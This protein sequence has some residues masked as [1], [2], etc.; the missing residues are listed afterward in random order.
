METT[1]DGLLNQR[2]K[3]EQPAQGYRVAIDTVLL[4]ASVPASDNSHVLDMGCGVGGAL[5]ALACRVPHINVI[6]LEFQSELASLGQANIQRNTFATHA[7]VEQGDVADLPLEMFGAFDH[8]MMNPPYHDATHHDASP[9]LNKQIAN[10]ESEA[11]LSVWVASAVKALKPDGMLTLIHRADRLLEIT[12]LLQTSFG[13]MIVKPVVPKSG[14][15]PKRVI[16]RA[17]RGSKNV[18]TMSASLVLHADD[19]RYTEA[20]EQILRHMAAIVF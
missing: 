16:V 13:A 5:L 4:A 11:D 17:Q 8:V 9:V 19:G 6:G 15:S 1:I 18:T 14:Q 7:R 20:V 2:V 12:D 10:T 3:F